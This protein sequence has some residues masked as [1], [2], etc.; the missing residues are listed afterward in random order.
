[1]N[2]L[3]AIVGGFASG[4]FLRS[5]FFTSWWPV[6]FAV[7]L[8]ALFGA[9]AFV[10]PRLAYSL[11]AIFCLCVALGMVRADFSETPPPQTF[12]ADL[13][14]KVSYTGVVAEDPDVRDSNQRV[15]IKVSKG[16]ETTRILAVIPRTTKL[17]VGDTVSIYGTLSLPEPF[18][19]DTGR[20]FR[21]D[22]YLEKSGV[23]FMMSFATARVVRD[24]P[25]YSLSGNLAKIK[26]WF[27]SGI[28]NA[29]PE[30]Y[31]SLS[32]GILIGGK[33]GLGTE[34][35]DAFTRTGI[36]HIVV[37]SGYNVMIVAEWVM[38]LFGKALL[39]KRFVFL[40]G[41]IA[42]AVFVGIAGA[43]TTAVRAGVMALIA[44]YARATGRTYTAGRALLVTVLAMI[45]WNP[46]YLVYDPGFALSVTATAGLIWLSPIID[47]LIKIKNAFLKDVLVTTLSAQ[48]A[49][50][51]ILLYETGNLS[52][53]SLPAN[54][55]VAPVI[56]FAMAFSA[57]AGFAGIIFGSFAP[58]VSSVVALP[59]YLLSAFLI[60]IAEIGARLPLASVSLPP[61]PFWLV[62]IAYGALIYFASSK[63]FSTTD[64]FTFAKNASM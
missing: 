41:A 19:G 18:E 20:I 21:Y 8:T 1:M 63:R 36:V 42:I 37:L 26:H 29:L 16:G 48:I 56:P 39:R 43:G 35:K 58:L 50:L 5:L 59:A 33:S 25:W 60:A 9:F 32:G 24:A 22:K 11:G 15:P 38:L 52:L 46:L 27:L 44:V 64:Q 40:A 47:A 6:L 62:L 54:I 49:V 53:V 14:K 31:A 55:L 10:R 57:I 3:L 28:T 7:L 4:I 45:L 2:Y 34:L 51:P 13:K 23:R 61:F 17:H 12:V 30:P